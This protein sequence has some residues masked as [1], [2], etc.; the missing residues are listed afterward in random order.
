MWLSVWTEKDRT[1]FKWI[2]HHVPTFAYY[3]EFPLPDLAKSGA[4]SHDLALSS[5]EHVFESL[6]QNAKRIYQEIAKY[7]VN[8][9]EDALSKKD[10]NYQFQLHTDSHKWLTSL[11]LRALCGTYSFIGLFSRYGNDVLQRTLQNL[12]VFL[13]CQYGTCSS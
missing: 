6:T 9:E 7:H 5:L 12:P 8:R 4:E 2:Y 3:S 10:G 1:A 13:F 11:L